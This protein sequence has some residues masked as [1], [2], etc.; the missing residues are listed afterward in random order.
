MT[1]CQTVSG[2]RQKEYSADSFPMRTRQASHVLWEAIRSRSIRGI[3]LNRRNIPIMS[4]PIESMLLAVNSNFLV[5][6]VSSDDMMGQLFASL[7][8]TVAAAES[9]IGSA[10]FVIT[11]RVRETIAVEF[12]NSIQDF[13]VLMDRLEEE[14]AGLKMNLYAI[15]EYLDEAF[16]GIVSHINNIEKRIQLI[17][18]KQKFANDAN[19]TDQGASDASPVTLGLM[20]EAMKRKEKVEYLR[21]VEIPSYTHCY[22]HYMDKVPEVVRP[23]T[24]DIKESMGDGTGGFIALALALGYRKE[25]WIKVQADLLVELSCFKQEYVKM[26]SVHGFKNCVENLSKSGTDEFMKMP[27]A[28]YLAASKYHTAVVF[29]SKAKSVTFLPL[30]SAIPKN[31]PNVISIGLVENKMLKLK[32][33][34]NYPMPEI[35]KLWFDY[36]YPTNGDWETYFQPRF[37]AYKKVF[38]CYHSSCFYSFLNACIRLRPDWPEAY[39]RKGVAWATLK[40]FNLAPNAFSEGLR[41]DPEDKELQIALRNNGLQA[42]AVTLSELGEYGQAASLLEKLS[43]VCS[44]LVLNYQKSQV[45]LMFIAYLAVKYELKDYEGSAAAYRSSASVSGNQKYDFLDVRQKFREGASVKEDLKV[46]ESIPDD[47]QAD[48]KGGV[49]VDESVPDNNQPSSKEEV[50]VVESVPEDSSHKD[51]KEEAEHKDNENPAFLVTI[52]SAG[53]CLLS[54]HESG[55]MGEFQ[56]DNSFTVEGDE[57]ED[58]SGLVDAHSKSKRGRKRC[59]GETIVGPTVNKDVSHEDVGLKVATLAPKEM[60]MIKKNSPVLQNY[61]AGSSATVLYIKNLAKDVITD[62][63]YF[64]FGSLFGTLE[65]AKSV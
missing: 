4:M 37:D 57:D 18:E 54:E 43:K 58:K 48:S 2:G 46:G 64:I 1:A 19:I 35:A 3:L 14:V 36:H 25:N 27:E 42:A 56:S 26:F 62:D 51:S 23:F 22:F 45:I 34:T 50:K 31:G 8:P 52:F 24:L 9:A 15:K 40:K 55:I 29:F 16:I 30:R 6:S 53:C 13:Q 11:F 7:V 32:L 44:A 12:I 47:S 60:P 49:K 65:A 21:D 63:F 59:R 20:K 28:G 38:A 39:Y 61:S 5:F 17:K 33:K 10:I 41:R